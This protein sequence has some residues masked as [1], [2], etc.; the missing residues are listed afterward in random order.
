M[1]NGLACAG[2]SVGMFIIPPLLRYLMDMYTVH[3]AL[4]V[5]A[6]MFLHLVI[7]GAV[8]RPWEFYTRGEPAIIKT[9]DTTSTAERGESKIPSN[10]EN[11]DEKSKGV[12]FESRSQ[13]DKTVHK[14]LKNGPMDRM[15]PIS[16]FPNHKTSLVSF[17]SCENYDIVTGLSLNSIPNQYSKEIRNRQ[18]KELVNIELGHC[19]PRTHSDTMKERPTRRARRPRY[20][21]EGDAQAT[22]PTPLM[23]GPAV[24]N[25]FISKTNGS[26]DIVSHNA[27]TA[28]TPTNGCDNHKTNSPQTNKKKIFDFNLM[29]NTVFL[30]FLGGLLLGHYGF[31]NQLFFLPAHARDIGISKQNAAWMLSAIGIS[32][33]IG[34]VGSGL[35]A[36]LGLVRKRYMQRTA[37][38]ILGIGSIAAPFITSFYGMVAYC[39]M[40]GL[41]GGSYVAM[42]PVVL[43][44]LIGLEKIASGMG[45]VQLFQGLSVPIGAPLLGLLNRSY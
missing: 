18:G 4:L 10:K 6:G 2:G 14:S 20:V 45:L 40:L 7:C 38:A 11:K 24:G 43:V 31:S 13:Q 30:T 12:I 35:F 36:N 5:T 29:K 34:R 28:A 3:E 44:D 21:S 26:P 42:V 19:R 39:C 16:E 9:A 32:D 23:K 37:L 27:N 22:M 17:L 15:Q 8:Y 1:A 33:L 41:A 25:E